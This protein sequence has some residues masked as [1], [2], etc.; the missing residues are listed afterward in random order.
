MR[1]WAALLLLGAA[2]C[3]NAPLAGFLDLVHPSH[4][5]RNGTDRERAG[6]DALGPVVGPPPP[7]GRLLAPAPPAA[8]PIA[9]ADSGFA[10]LAPRD[11]TPPAPGERP[12]LGPLSIPNA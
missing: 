6:G 1:R 4:V 7:G 8:A 9:P 10:P 2:G 5:Y 11:P 12:G 3:T